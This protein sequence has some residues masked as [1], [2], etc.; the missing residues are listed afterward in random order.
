MSAYQ[1]RDNLQIKFLRY[2][3]FISTDSFKHV[4][5]GLKIKARIPPQNSQNGI[6]V[7]EGV[8]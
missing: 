3:F 5:K 8:G 1:V 2:R 4:R 6:A 7:L